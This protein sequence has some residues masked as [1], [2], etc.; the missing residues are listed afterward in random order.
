MR[1]RPLMRS[2]GSSLGKL[3][4]APATSRLAS[5][6][7]N[8][9]RTLQDTASNVG[10]SVRTLETCEF[11]GSQFS[12]C[13]FIGKCDTRSHVFLNV[14]PEV[15]MSTSLTPNARDKVRDQNTF[16]FKLQAW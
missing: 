15:L 7:G 3:V 9:T 4:I 2:L 5:Y 13:I 14:V 16:P 1:I 10:G 12:K 11:V 6:L 8:F